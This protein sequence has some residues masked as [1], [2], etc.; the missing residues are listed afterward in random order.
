MD[1]WNWIAPRAE[2]IWSR[3]TNSGSVQGFQFQ[4]NTTSA[5][6]NELKFANARTIR[7]S[8][9]VLAS[10]NVAVAFATAAGI[11]WESYTVA[12]RNNP[13]RRI[14]SFKFNFM[15]PTETFPFIL[16]CGI[17]VQGITFAAVQSM[18]M[19]SLMI[20]GCAVPSQIM[21][22]A[23][24]IVP[25]IQLIFAME[26]TVRA[27]N[28]HHFPTRGK[29][30]MP[31]CLVL[32]GV[33]LLATFLVTFSMRPPN[34]C[35]ASL[36][37]LLQRFRLECF[38]LLTAIT[39]VL[40][41]AGMV[42]FFKLYTNTAI[43]VT[44][45]IA[46]SHMV[47]YLAV[48]VISTTLLIPFFFS[49]SFKDPRTAGSKTLGLS[50]MASV[51]SN[52][53]G[54]MTGS[55]YLFLR[56]SKCTIIAPKGLI[57]T[58][59]KR[60]KTG[61]RIWAPSHFDFSYQ[62]TQP[63]S[64]PSG[65]RRTDSKESLIEREK[66]EEEKV[67]SPKGTPM[68]EHPHPLSFSRLVSPREPLRIPEPAQLPSS[69]APRTPRT[70][71]T[72]RSYSIFPTN[73]GPSQLKSAYLLPT[74]TYTPLL[75]TPG[76]ATKSTESLLPPPL[77]LGSNHRRDSSVVS[78][79]TVQIGL[80]FS[81]VNDMPPL[82]SVYLRDSTSHDLGCPAQLQSVNSRKPSPLVTNHASMPSREIDIEYPEE[83]S[84]TTSNQK[85]VENNNGFRSGGVTLSPD[86][87]KPQKKLPIKVT[88]PRGVGF[89]APSSRV[90]SP[91]GRISPLVL[92]PESEVKRQDWI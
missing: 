74:A 60:P 45:R 25:Y 35:F 53:S 58:E 87:Y 69:P 20:L 84:L 39:A 44:E 64:P 8:F 7:T 51:V 54:L 4:D 16:S 17:V 9:I 1:S 12:W 15:G 55:L 11:F 50:M 77:I 18:G 23:L 92:Q 65:L 86:V 67:E 36:F 27:L 30:I 37:W 24:F 47:H 79:A 83:E 91:G 38:G 26:M 71:T 46:A 13:N 70:P 33:C 10:F 68:S 40:F 72:K 89:S 85:A 49:L 43:D 73:E 59:S 34:F 22:P 78:S 6:I 32:V 81:N 31:V 21:L 3:Q 41:I 48:G 29:W 42:I 61:I 82:N 14:R 5:V 63:I 57:S 19:E 62:I 56:S 80:R 66:D 90:Q 2:D 76:I 88:S 52:L 28:R 75:S